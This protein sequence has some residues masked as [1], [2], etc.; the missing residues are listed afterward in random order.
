M[1]MSRCFEGR[2]QGWMCK[3]ADAHMIWFSL[4]QWESVIANYIHRRHE[5]LSSISTWS[6]IHEGVCKYICHME[7]LQCYTIPPRCKIYSYL[8][9]KMFPFLSPHSNPISARFKWSTTTAVF[10]HFPERILTNSG[11]TDKHFHPFCTVFVCTFKHYYASRWHR[12]P[13]L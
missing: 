1:K 10:L 13:S 3:R 7:I 8:A 11:I 2:L 4:L 6:Q 9:S 12:G 5:L